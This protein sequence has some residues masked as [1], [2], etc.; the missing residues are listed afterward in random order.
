MKD[1]KSGKEKSEGKGEK[2]NSKHKEGR[3]ERREYKKDV[4]GAK[5]KK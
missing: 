4:R 3:R 2:R 1:V 5:D